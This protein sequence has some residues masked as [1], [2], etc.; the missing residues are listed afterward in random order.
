MAAEMLKPVTPT[1]SSEDKSVVTEYFPHLVLVHNKAEFTDT[2]PYHL[3]HV[4]AF[5][6]RVL[7][8]SRLQWRRKVEMN[9]ILRI[10]C[11]SYF[12]LYQWVKLSL[13]NIFC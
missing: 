5:Y 6:S 9:L 3:E 13:K 2:E 1:V 8:K 12:I 11:S 7:K 4:E 10:E